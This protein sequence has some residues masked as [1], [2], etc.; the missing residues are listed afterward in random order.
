MVDD[1]DKKVLKGMLDSTVQQAI[2]VLGGDYAKMNLE[3]LIIIRYFQILK[4]PYN[5]FEFKLDE[6]FDFQKFYENLEKSEH[7]D[8]V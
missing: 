6:P 1:C 5:T 7:K 2:G 4:N 3:Q 8:L